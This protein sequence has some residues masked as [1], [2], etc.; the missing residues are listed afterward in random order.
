MSSRTTGRKTGQRP[1]VRRFIY[2]TGLCEGTN[3]MTTEG[4]LPVE[5]LHAG[6]RLITDRGLR[7]IRHIN[8]RALT[9]CPIEVRRGALG[10]GR[11]AQDMYLAPDQLVHLADWRSHRYYGADQRAVPVSRLHDGTHITWGEHPGDLLVYDLELEGEQV[12]F[13]EGMQVMSAR[14]PTPAAANIAAQ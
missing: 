9:D 13:A 6:D 2:K 3:I 10:P 11:P 8:A 14:L 12:I 4:N 7:T 1:G 5:Y